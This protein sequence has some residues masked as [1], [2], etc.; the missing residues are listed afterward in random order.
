MSPNSS[1]EPFIPQYFEVEI[2]NKSGIIDRTGAVIHPI[3]YDKIQLLKSMDRREYREGA[4]HDFFWVFQKGRDFEIRSLKDDILYQDT[5]IQTNF[6]P[7]FLNAKIDPILEIHQPVSG[8][9]KLLNTRTKTLTKAYFETTIDERVITARLFDN[10]KLVDYYDEQLNL[11]YSTTED[12]KLRYLFTNEKLFSVFNSEGKFSKIINP[13][14]ETIITGDYER[15]LLKYLNSEAYIWAIGQLVLD[16]SE[17]FFNFKSDI[18]TEDG[19]LLNSCEF[20]LRA[21][22]NKYADFQNFFESTAPSYHAIGNSEHYQLL[23]GIKNDKWGAF[24]GKGVLVIPFEYEDIEGGVYL[25]ETLNKATY[26]CVKNG[27]FGQINSANEIIHSFE[28]DHIEFNWG[29]SNLNYFEKKNGGFIASSENETIIDNI[30]TAFILQRYKFYKEHKFTDKYQFP[31]QY[32]TNYLFVVKFDTLYIKGEAGF[33]RCDSSLIQF[34][35]PD[36][37]IAN[38]MVNESGA[39]IKRPSSQDLVTLP[40][41]YLSIDSTF[42]DVY[43]FEGEKIGS[44]ADFYLGGM[45]EHH[46]IVKTSKNTVGAR[47]K[48]GKEWLLKPQYLEIIIDTNLENQYWVKTEKN[49]N[50][51]DIGPLSGQWQLINRQGENLL[52]G[53]TFNLPPINKHYLFNSKIVKSGDKFGLIDNS[54]SLILPTDYDVIIHSSKPG[55]YILQKD[56]FWV[57][58][59]ETG[60]FSDWYSDLADPKGIGVF[61]TTS[62]TNSDTLVEFIRFNRNSNVEKLI[63]KAHLDSINKHIDLATIFKN[64]FT[65]TNAYLDRPLSIGKSIYQPSDLLNEMIPFNNLLILQEFNYSVNRMYSFGTYSASF[66]SFPKSI[67]PNLR[68]IPESILKQHVSTVYLENPN[69]IDNSKRVVKIASFLYANNSFYSQHIYKGRYEKNETYLENYVLKISS[70]PTTFYKLFKNQRKIDSALYTYIQDAVNEAQLF[71]P[72]CLN[73][74]QVYGIYIQN[75]TFVE[76]GIMFYQNPTSVHVYPEDNQPAFVPY[77]FLKQF[78]KSEILEL[79]EW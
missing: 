12:E 65:Q 71:G 41:Y 8:K 62:I 29:N 24:N 39:L 52:N 57:L 38:Y 20:K 53:K 60:L 33:V 17:D 44:I 68:I 18:Y 36:I 58:F 72:S 35:K 55:I 25:D 34:K 75:F 50:G 21:R 27:K 67:Y 46:L 56:A 61:K 40:Y 7:Y 48:N 3:G 64:D 28:Y 31:V 9:Y 4:P 77:D 78:L 79:G 19:V 66:K 13:K 6:S 69:G 43:N 32:N 45:L 11:I 26:K 42:A 23:C 54:N 47:S 70:E 15:I 49:P 2:D 30:D 76:G 37:A 22:T 16:E 59:S 74:P 1:E 14:G 73:F 51:K 10:S 5:A 63:A